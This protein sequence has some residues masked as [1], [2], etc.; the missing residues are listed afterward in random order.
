MDNSKCRLFFHFQQWALQVPTAAKKKSTFG[1]QAEV[2]ADAH[3]A[4]RPSIRRS[5]TATYI[6]PVSSQVTYSYTGMVLD[7]CVAILSQPSDA[8]AVAHS[9]VSPSQMLPWRLP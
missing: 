9:T 5:Y 6:K 3:L 2:Y 7:R 4:K 8:S 1:H